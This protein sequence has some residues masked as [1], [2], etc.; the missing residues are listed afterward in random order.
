[1]IVEDER[2]IDP[3]IHAKRWFIIIAV[4]LAAV[5][6]VL[7]MTIVNVAM[8]QMMGSL[9]ANADQITWVLTSYI[10]SSAIVMLLTGF[11]VAK[12]GR[13]RLLL[14]NIAGFLISSMLCGLALNLFQIVFFRTLQGVFGASLIPLSQFVLRDTFSKREQG[15]AMAIWGTGIM[16]APV[17]GPT[18]GGYITELLNWR[19]V[20]YINIP[21]CIISFIM[22]L[23]FIPDSKRENPS[24][25]WFGL[26]TMA[27]GVGC[28]QVFLDRG[29][30]SDW[31]QSNTIIIL[32][33][34]AILCLILFIYHGLTSKK[35]IVDLTI[36]RDWNFA[37]C[38]FLLGVFCALIFAL[39][40]VQPLMMESLLNYPIVTTGLIMAPRGLASAIVMIASGK[41]MEK[42]DA[43]IFIG[44]GVFFSALGGY[45]MC[46]F[47]LN[48][49]E[50]YI[51]LTMIVQGIGMGFF[52]VP[53]SA[54]SLFTLKEKDIASATGMFSFGRSLGSSIGI[55]IFSTIVSREGQAS[56]HQ[57]GGHISRFNPNLNHWLTHTHMN[58][59]QPHTIAILA[60]ILGG[61]SHM[62]AF[63]D[64][65]WVAAISFA[66]MLPFV[67]TI[68]KAV[69][70][71]GMMMH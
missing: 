41:L 54:L 67:F 38:T 57:L 21:V 60:N 7:D 64:S 14:I 8:P 39:I 11:L 68:K 42:Y 23:R 27:L 43:R 49:D 59:S 50:H 12:F 31:F 30:S 36:F 44:L 70:K 19:W 9:S 3:E 26:I 4:M 28:L 15:M 40:A 52:F 34:V 37:I 10:V 69:F 22:T 46:R 58:L 65:F 61:Q 17:L 18:L 56:W 47:S 63:I 33:F 20:F 32:A 66:L 53:I 29:N 45:M 24:M 6:E 48:V 25:D 71:N 13:K 16:A 2:T 1:M 55:S 51:I 5:I 62:I 35:S